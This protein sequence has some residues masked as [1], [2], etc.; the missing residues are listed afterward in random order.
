MKVGRGVGGVER[1]RSRTTPRLA[2][3]GENRGDG[4]G[5]ERAFAQVQCEMPVRRTSGD[6]EWTSDL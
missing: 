6:V 1:V 2:I 5:A 4:L 3:T